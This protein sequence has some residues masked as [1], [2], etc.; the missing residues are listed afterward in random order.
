ML[1]IVNR[2]C[3]DDRTPRGNHCT[4]DSAWKSTGC[5]LLLVETATVRCMYQLVLWILLKYQY[6]Y[7]VTDVNSMYEEMHQ[8]H[9]I[10]AE[11]LAGAQ[12]CIAMAINLTHTVQ[13]FDWDP[14][15]HSLVPIVKPPPVALDQQDAMLN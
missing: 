12:V 1:S 14:Q 4:S 8:R 15:F 10:E 11:S 6:Q 7:Q 5:A 9:Q 13:A 3:G 2:L